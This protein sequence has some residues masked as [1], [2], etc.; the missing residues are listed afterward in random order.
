MSSA[1]R[2]GRSGIFFSAGLEI[3]PAFMPSSPRTLQHAC[4]KQAR[5]ARRTDVQAKE[6]RMTECRHQILV[7][8]P[9]RVIALMK[10]ADHDPAGIVGYAVLTA[11][12]TRLR[13]ELTLEDARAWVDALIEEEN[14]HAQGGRLRSVMP[15]RGRGMP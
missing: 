6:S 1:A 4:M 8:G 14:V 11:S 10:E 13:Y 3:D 2:N 15:Q 5:K 12:G 9:Y 7:N